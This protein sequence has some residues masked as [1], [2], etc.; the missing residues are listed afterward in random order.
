MAILNSQPAFKRS[1][2]RLALFV[3]RATVSEL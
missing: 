3:I 2:E 1:D